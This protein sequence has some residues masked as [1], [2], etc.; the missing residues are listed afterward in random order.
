MEQILPS[1]KHVC[2]WVVERYQYVSRGLLL[3]SPLAI[4]DVEGNSL[5]FSYVIAHTACGVNDK[6]EHSGLGEA[7]QSVRTQERLDIITSF[8]RPW[9]ID[10]SVISDYH[11]AL[12]KTKDYRPL[13]H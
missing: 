13:N 7:H 11:L 3:G 12:C 5:G 8:N 1:H 10:L 9:L 4:N 6:A 2:T